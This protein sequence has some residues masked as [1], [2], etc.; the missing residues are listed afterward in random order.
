MLRFL[1]RELTDE[2]RVFAP[3][4][5]TVL[6]GPNILS[7]AGVHLADRPDAAWSVHN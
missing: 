1:H 7:D 3:G 5:V 2:M 6:G 4:Y